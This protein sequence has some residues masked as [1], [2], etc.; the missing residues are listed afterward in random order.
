MEYISTKEASAKWGISTIRITILAN[1]GRI[2]GAKLMG[3][4][5]LIPVNATKPPERKSSR[6]KDAH[7]LEPVFSFP[8]YHFRPDWYSIQAEQFSQEQQIL[9][10][11]ETALLECRFADAYALAQSILSSPDDIVTEVGCLWTA[12]ICCMALNKADDFSK[13][14]LRLQM[15]L[16]QGFPYRDDLLPIL[17]A[18][19]TYSEPI[20]SF[21]N[22]TIYKVDVHEQCIPLICLLAAYAQLS[23]EA[24]EAGTADITLLELNLR[25]LETTGAVVATEMM[26][27]HLLGIY[28]LRHD[29]ESSKRH[30]QEMVRLAFENK[31]YFPLVTYYRYF[32]SILAPVLALYPDEF[33]KNCKA[34]ITQYEVNVTA[35]SGALNQHAV[36]SKLT[37]AD[38]PY[39]YAFLKGLTNAQVEKK[40]D[41]PSKEVIRM[42]RRICRKLGV[43]SKKELLEYLHNYM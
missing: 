33:Q 11:A 20:S 21:A 25:F 4:N 27:C 30:A 38:Y 41:V 18:L 43:K 1:E 23:K 37:G 12:G 2:P 29:M 24:M 28:Y 17:Y 5:W 39:I 7:K 15:L 8:L 10:Q 19:K 32:T 40:L 6:K 13:I 36:I 34:M 42:Q 14:Y 35:F 31:Y 26:H 22:N 3:K 16:S 9:L